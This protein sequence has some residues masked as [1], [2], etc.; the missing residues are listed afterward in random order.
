LGD[1]LRAGKFFVI[2]TTFIHIEDETHFILPKH[3]Y[4]VL[5]TL[6]L[7]FG[8][9]AYYFWIYLP[10]QEKL[11]I[12]KQSRALEQ[13]AVNFR[14]KD[15]VYR[16]T[17]PEYYFEFDSITL[18][19][20]GNPDLI[21]D[22]NNIYEKDST[23]YIV[24]S[25]IVYFQDTIRIIC[26]VSKI[27]PLPK[28][29]GSLFQPYKEGLFEHFI[30]YKDTLLAHKTWDAYTGIYVDSL[31]GSPPNITYSL[32]LEELPDKYGLLDDGQDV[33]MSA[34]NYKLF[35][36]RFKTENN[37]WTLYAL[38]SKESFQAEI[39]RI[40]VPVVITI[41]MVILILI[42]S[43]PLIKLGLMSSIERLNRKDVVLS[44]S[45][46]VICTGLLVLILLFGITFQADKT[47]IDTRLKN[48]SSVVAENIDYE[49][50]GIKKLVMNMEKSPDLD[51]VNNTDRELSF[52]KNPKLLQQLKTDYHFLR[53]LYWMDIDGRRIHQV[54]TVLDNDDTLHYKSYKE[55][56]YFR[57]IVEGR[58]WKY[59]KDSKPFL[60]ESIISWINSDKLL[61]LSVP[62]YD[63]S[64]NIKN[65]LAA[66]VRFH[67]V[68]D[69]L[70]PDPFSFY[71]VDDRGNILF[72]SN[73]EK[74]L[75]ENLLIELDNPN[76]I[77][78]AIIGKNSVYQNAKY[79]SDNHRIF[80]TPLNNTPWMLITSYDNTY[81]DL[82]YLQI[83]SVSVIYI[84]A[85]G[86]FVFFHLYLLSLFYSRPS[87]LSKQAFNYSWLW[88]KEDLKGSY[89]KF[90]LYNTG[91]AILLI[92][93]YVSSELVTIQVLSSFLYAV[94]FANSSAWLIFRGQL[95]TRKA[96]RTIVY[97]ATIFVSLLI[98][99]IT[100][101]LTNDWYKNSIILVLVAGLSAMTQIS[102][103]NFSERLVTHRGWLDFKKMYRIMLFTFLIVSSVL[104]ALFL[105]R[106]AYIQEKKIWEKF[107]MYRISQ[108]E[109]AR[110]ARMRTIYLTNENHWRDKRFLRR[111][112]HWESITK[113]LVFR[114]ANV[115]R[116]RILL[117]LQPPG[118][119]FPIKPDL[120]L[121]IYMWL[122]MGLYSP[123]GETNGKPVFAIPMVFVLNIIRINF[124][125]T[126]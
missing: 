97:A 35:S 56:E 72:H 67:P 75:Q 98:F 92:I 112:Q 111:Q 32:K 31:N 65:V 81:N 87:K 76:D 3:A 68:I 63:T 96:R 14:N 51:P 6:F 91:L 55:R 114:Y 20:K 2:K 108:S 83:I 52:F 89:F 116:K 39:N 85:I 28:N 9:F 125:R 11:L 44:S 123:V 124:R 100:T 53:N 122:P 25:Q 71:I 82:P 109:V 4:I 27:L 126:Q 69:P 19:N 45:S 43:L 61:V 18:I 79:G 80:I 22:Y 57:E 105:Y 12:A 94:L 93:Y 86:F 54:S 7:L 95:K 90:A 118:T 107:D 73:S 41:V 106:T 34:V 120:F 33:R 50:E 40:P 103:Q 58:G 16:K 49:L 60:L 102:W 47:K 37:T 84:L 8:L 78:S 101:R 88:P 24:Y 42:F 121:R 5:S 66:S 1:I 38:V 64:D 59:E 46:F 13:I 119:I 36:T 70:L 117:Y 26:P 15:N 23:R 115:I 110:N 113:H 21:L 62:V 104:P 77:R 30:L 17:A 29:E 10:S 99:V 48:L 74:N